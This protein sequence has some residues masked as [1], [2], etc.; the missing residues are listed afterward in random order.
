MFNTRKLTFNT[1][2]SFDVQSIVIS[3]DFISIDSI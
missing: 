3:V 1:F 2:I